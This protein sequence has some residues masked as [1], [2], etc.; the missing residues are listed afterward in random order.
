MEVLGD[1]SAFEVFVSV[2]ALMT[3]GYTAYKS[4]LQGPR[5]T[6]F[7]GESVTLVSNGDE[8]LRI[9][10]SGVAVNKAAK[11]GVLNPMRV[12][13]KDPSDFEIIGKVT[14][15]V[16]AKVDPPSLSPAYALSVPPHGSTPFHIEA[17]IEY[18]EGLPNVWVN[19][20]YH[21]QLQGWIVG[22][23]SSTK[24]LDC[25]FAFEV[26]DVLEMVLGERE[27]QFT[28]LCSECAS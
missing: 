6:L 7:T 22:N 27:G 23:R 24:H 26:P 9:W 28:V 4:L 17:T 25:G 11:V 1:L 20:K 21:A 19:G 3:G 14:R 15:F 8:P 2:V 5:I 12:Y 16:D 13:L 18:P 10:V